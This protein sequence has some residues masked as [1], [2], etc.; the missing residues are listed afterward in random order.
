MKSK[1]I[2]LLL[3][4]FSFY[5]FAQE[6]LVRFPAIDPSGNFLAFTYQGDIWVMNLNSN[7]QH[8]LTIH[9]AYDSKPVWSPDG[10]MIA[11]SSN[12]YG[13]EDIFVM[14]A[15]GSSLKRLSFHPSSDIV[16]S[17]NTQDKIVFET[18]HIQAQV[19]R[20]HEIYYVSPR[21][22]NPQ[23]LID[24]LGSDAI[25]SSDGKMVAFV[26]GSC[27][28]TRQAYQG[29]ANRDIWLYD[30]EKDTYTQLTQENHNQFKPIW[31]TNNE[32]LYISSNGGS[33]YQLNSL[34]LKNKTVEIA[35]QA[36]TKFTD[37]GLRFFSYCPKTHTAL[38]ESGEHI[39][40]LNTN[41]RNSKNL[42]ISIKSES[43]KNNW[44]HEVY[45]GDAN[46]YSL[47]PN[48]KYLALAIHGNIFISQAKDKDNFTKALTNDSFFND[49]PEWLNDTT[50][51]FIS[52]RNG[53]K[54]ILMLQSE[55][56]NQSNLFKSLKHKIS[57][58]TD[59]TDDVQTMTISNNRDQIAFV[60][61]YGK[62]ISA[63]IS[64][65]GELSNRRI[66]LDSWARPTGI[67]W[68]PDD[69]YLAYSKKDLDFNQEIYIQAADNSTPP[70]NVSMH[71]RNDQSPSWSPDGK[72]LAFSSIR[73]YGNYDIWYVW[74]Q[75]KDWE[76]SMDEWKLDGEDEN[77]EK[78]KEKKA[79]KKVEVKIDFKNIHERLFQLTSLPGNESQ[80]IFSQ[81]GKTIFFN[82]NSNE[83]G[84]TDLYKINWDKKDI[85]EITKDGKA[86]NAMSLSPDGKYIYM[87]IKG[88]KTARL[89]IAKNKIENI[90]IKA[91]SDIDRL[92]LK[93][94]VFNEGWKTIKTGFYDPNFH[95]RDWDKIGDIY[96]PIALSAS[97]D[98]DFQ[99]IFNWMLGEINASHMGMRNPK[100]KTKP[101]EKTA[102][103][104]IDFIIENDQIKITKVLAGSPADKEESKLMI[105]DII[106]SINGEALT[107][108]SNLYKYLAN[109]ANEATLLGIMRNGEKMEIIIRPT[110]SLAKQKYEDWVSF[111]RKLVDEY[112]GGK[113]G[114]LHIKAMGWT[115]FERFERDLMAA[116]YGK[117]GILI[118]VRYNG[119][120][121][122]TDYLMA[123]L[124]V[125]QHA[126]TIP[127]GASDNLE[128]DHKKFRDH[129]A[130]GERLPFASWTK[131]SIA[132]C[133]QNSYSNA[134]IFSHAY[135]S[136]HLGTLVGTPTFG[137]VI[138]TSSRRLSN[139]GSI[140][141]PFRAWYVKDDDK[142]MEFNAA[143]P[144][145]IVQIKPDSRINGKDEQ[146]QKAVEILL[147]QLGQKAKNEH[148][149]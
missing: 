68:S 91:A 140:R 84:K 57:K 40:S 46:A 3:S 55:D 128:R 123:V 23:K 15:D 17:W 129:Y 53:I 116:G 35:E 43:R 82:S 79:N 71:P 98:R 136:N 87:I 143:V 142:N 108:Y 4:L 76:K 39:I 141:L 34:T 11:F 61:S 99:D 130:F 6:S 149:N 37:L 92:A 94:Q 114:Y 72:K 121:W 8:R 63:Y 31:K 30:K 81:D 66:L 78:K 97:T 44:E 64:P 138:S 62:L 60:E 131:P 28:I 126:Y 49:D 135:K 86:G 36:F 95:G 21:G 38:L 120:G 75:K 134:E 111:N 20:D 107:K 113:L 132:L 16:D 145:V 9:E 50:L 147:N 33:V 112:S 27:R 69:K 74:L 85:K 32:L 104:G 70:V 58:L 24:V 14:N 133:N 56:R 146:L 117:E 65:N 7:T 106:E 54:N 144:D 13:S 101:S 12:R 19:E 18:R 119:G 47:S 137:A 77:Q 25:E 48:G 5:S 29:S 127:R 22:G 90:N 96:K 102:L 59:L 115:S 26:R 118:D 93:E 52:D 89:N 67:C 10:K 42:D 122:T 103:L 83:K 45:K 105:G 100:P 88:G 125:K 1:I 109:K 80:A 2:L 148:S 41:T 124:N 73:N 110:T 51:L 139:G